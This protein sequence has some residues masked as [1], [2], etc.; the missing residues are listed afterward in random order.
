MDQETQQTVRSVVSKTLQYPLDLVSIG[1]VD[2]LDITEV[3]PY[4]GVLRGE[5][6]LAEVKDDTKDF[7]FGRVR[8]GHKVHH[9]EHHSAHW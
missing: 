5:P 1:G 2:T 7:V 6:D 9:G 3:V 8:F 4:A